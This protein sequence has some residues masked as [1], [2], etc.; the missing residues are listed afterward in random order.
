MMLSLIE[1][2]AAI[3]TVAFAVLIYACL[4]ETLWTTLRRRRWTK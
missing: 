3:E 4:E 1:V 2:V